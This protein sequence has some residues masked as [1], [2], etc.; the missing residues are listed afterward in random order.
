MIPNPKSE[1][2][3]LKSLWFPQRA[4]ESGQGDSGSVA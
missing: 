3:N 1:I 4:G 2:Q